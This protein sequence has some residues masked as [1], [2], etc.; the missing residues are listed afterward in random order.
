MK[1]FLTNIT[2]FLLLSVLLTGCFKSS[3]ERAAE[4]LESGLQL[5]GE[6]DLPRAIVEFRN[7][8]KFDEDNLEAYRQMARASRALNDVP[9]AYASFLRVVEQK[10]DNLEARI[11]LSEMAFAQESW[12]EFDRHSAAL[13]QRTTDL[14]DAKAVGLAAAYRQAVLENDTAERDAL[15]RQVAAFAP[16]MPDSDILPR[17][18][19]DGYVASGRYDSALEV[20]DG[21]IA[22]NP[23]DIDLYLA[24]LGLLERLNDQA[25]LQATLRAML[26]SF[27]E[28]EVAQETYLAFLLSSD[29]LDEAET[30]LEENLTSTAPAEQNSAFLRLITFLRQTKGDQAALE[31]IDAGLTGAQAQNQMRQILRA[32]LLFE[33]GER[34]A[35]ITDLAAVLAAEQTGLRRAEILNAQTTLARMQMLNGDEAAARARIETV[36][37]EDSGLPNALKM[38]AAWRIA[39]DNTTAAINDLRVV[40]D[41]VPDDAEAMVLMANAYRRSGDQALRQEFLARAAESADNTPRYALLLARALMEDGK[42]LQAE[43]ALISSLRRMPD[44]MEVLQTLGEIYLLLDDLPRTAQVAMTL[45]KHDSEQAKLIAQ[46]LQAELVARRI[47]VDEALKFLE[48]QAVQGDVS[49]VLAIIQAQLRTG[50]TDDA[51]RTARNAVAENPDNPRLRNVLALSYASGRDFDAAE[52]E[53]G[54]LLDTFPDAVPLYLQLARIKAAEGD[55]SAGAAVIDSGLA[56]RP[57]SADLLWAKASYLEQ[58]GDIAEAIEIYE[59]LYTRNSD[60]AVVANNLASLLVTYRDDPESLTRADVI[61]RR[62]KGSDVPAFQDTFGYVRFR[63]GDLQEALAYLEPAAAGLPDDPTVQFHLGEVYAALG[64]PAD[65]IAQ[66]RK[67]L[68]VAG[69]LADADFRAELTTQIAQIKNS[70]IE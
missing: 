42:L 64:R 32:T 48:Q 13:G 3:E 26:S 43:S 11:A 39:D 41:S 7:T 58:N 38:R 25:D 2:A 47:G 19:L 27:P 21:S 10:P 69:P 6:G 24:K 8:L 51:V 44:H 18:L 33:M 16:D 5:V 46:G 62:L 60:S 53:L 54:I 66:M 50:R 70:Q 23:D 35:G 29:R 52:A 15:I 59:T 4:H 34:D 68:E 63:Q 56:I 45:E 36:L 17:I 1:R 30:F 12:D 55:F 49:T 9:T 14:P 28:N 20:L 40:L 37:A 22:H 67:A 65:A 31:R 61:S 57:R